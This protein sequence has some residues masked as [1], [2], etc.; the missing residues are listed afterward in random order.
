[1]SSTELITVVGHLC[2]LSSYLI[3]EAKYNV[4]KVPII[5]EIK[6]E[7]VVIYG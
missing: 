7:G 5:K 4:E 6:K 1:V 3:T 2:H